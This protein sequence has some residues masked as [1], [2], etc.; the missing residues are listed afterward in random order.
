[1]LRPFRT[2]NKDKSYADAIK[3][4]NFVTRF[5]GNHFNKR[6]E[7][8]APYDPDLQ[9][10]VGKYFDRRTGLPV[11]PDQLR[12]YEEAL[13]GYHYH[14]EP[15][16]DNGEE[17]SQGET[18]RRHVVVQAVKLIGKE[19]DH[20]EE[21]RESGDESFERLVEYG[22]SRTD[23]DNFSKT[24]GDACRR[25]K[26]KVV[27]KESKIVD[28]ELRRIVRGEVRAKAK[29]TIAVLQAVARLEQSKV[30]EVLRIEACR[31]WLGNAV[32]ELGL[33]EMGRRFG[34]D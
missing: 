14:T 16:F 22:F 8:I 33:T 1:L 17:V 34:V 20:W 24:V 29:T 7:P 9:V 18:R 13:G 2:L 11:H 32:A 23:V 5:Q 31:S 3:P 10:A 25:F 21:A 15:K 26:V 28:R 12:T 30:H 6:L 27:A 4:Y 19:A